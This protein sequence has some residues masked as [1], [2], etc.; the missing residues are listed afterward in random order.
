MRTLALLLLLGCAA[1]GCCVE[2]TDTGDGEGGAGGGSS[3]R[4]EPCPPSE[5]PCETLKDC[6]PTGIHCVIGV[7]VGGLCEPVNL[8]TVDVLPVDPDSG[9]PLGKHC[10][11]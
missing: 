4:E 2:D 3:S 9:L 8:A 1:L 10:R 11:R 6:P 5:T 7:C